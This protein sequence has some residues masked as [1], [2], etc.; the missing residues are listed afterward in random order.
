[1]TGGI[2]LLSL[3]R[4]WMVIK[5]TAIPLLIGIAVIGSQRTKFQLVPKLF[6]SLMDLDKIKEAFKANNR[7]GEL[8]RKINISSYLIGAS[9]FLS[10]LLNYLLAVWILVGDPGSVE[11][12]ESLGKMTA[13]SFPVIA[14]PMMVVTGFIL[15][16]LITTIKKATGLDLEEFMKQ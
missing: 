16:D 3:D 6:G 13:L 5:E 1:M 7:D 4:K 9:F 15:Y 11:F 2:G 8:D 12:N 10:A 14:I